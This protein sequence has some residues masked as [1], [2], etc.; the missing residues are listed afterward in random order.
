MSLRVTNS[1]T[2]R[3]HRLIDHVGPWT[4]SIGLHAVLI[5]VGLLVTWSIIRMDEHLPSPVITS[6]IVAMTPIMP[7]H[8]TPADAVQSQAP[9]M[10]EL[11]ALASPPR[12]PAISA[13]TAATQSGPSRSVPASFAGA[14]LGVAGD[15]VF[16]LDAS[17]SMIAWLPFVID[18]VERTLA[19]M[20][21][22]QRFAIRYFAG[23]DVH[24]APPRRLTDVTPAAAEIAI[25]ALRRDASRRMQRGS[26]PTGAL[27]EALQLK[28]DLIVL[29][30]EGLAGRG[31]WAVDRDSVLAAL[32]QANPVNARTALRPVRIECIR[33][34]SRSANDP[35][36]LL[37]AIAAT[38]G[39]GAMRT[40]TLEDLDR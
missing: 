34:V 33:L 20:H 19:A 17:G 31:Q 16:V 13:P 38:H 15:V 24:A 25:A 39:G 37:E 36:P 10:P 30:S 1:P 6:D 14:S 5:I 28:P 8:D 23:D 22:D 3:M 9:S 2:G 4:V 21:T 40:V 26:N 32:D 12:L 7:L 11:P 35:T 29:L 18:E 27:I